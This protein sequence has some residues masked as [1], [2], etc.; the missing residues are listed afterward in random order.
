[1]PVEMAVLINL[2]HFHLTGDVM[3]RHGDDVMAISGWRW[4]QG[5]VVVRLAK[6]DMAADNG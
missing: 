2:A 5:G 3:A 6:R 1:M 4:G